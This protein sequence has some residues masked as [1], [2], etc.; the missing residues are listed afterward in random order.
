M[1]TPLKTSEGL[2]GKGGGAHEVNRR[3]VLASHQFGHA[4][5]SQFCAGMNLPSPVT[6]KAYNEHLIQIEKAVM[7]NAENLMPDA[8]TRLT[9]KVAAEKPNDLE[10]VGDQKIANVSVTVDG[11]WQKRGH[12]SKIRVV[13]VISV[14]TGEILDYSVKSL[15]CHECKA[16]NGVDKDTD[17]YKV[18]KDAHASSC[19]INHHGSSEEME[20][21][22]AATEIFSRS[23]EKRL[24]KYTTFVGDGDSS[25][26][27]RV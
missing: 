14:D 3:S 12:S 15:V 25:S 20:T 13:F 6:K 27:G 5:L 7:K 9:E 2:G 11:T 24:L 1:E 23:I 4:G 26:F 16:C 21:V 8:A 10:E 22:A 19:Q 17:E 18:W